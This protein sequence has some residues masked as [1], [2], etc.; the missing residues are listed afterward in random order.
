MEDAVAVKQPPQLQQPARKYET[1]L[2]FEL[3]KSLTV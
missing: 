2:W 1:A 3:I